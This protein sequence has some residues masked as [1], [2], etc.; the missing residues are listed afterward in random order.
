MITHFLQARN[1]SRYEEDNARTLFT[2]RNPFQSE[3]ISV[4]PTLAGTTPNKEAQ[5]V[6]K[7]LVPSVAGKLV[8]QELSLPLQISP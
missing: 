4:S 3:L 5:E 2:S 7:A 6:L 8:L 1:L